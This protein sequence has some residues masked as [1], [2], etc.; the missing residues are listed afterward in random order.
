[1]NKARKVLYWAITIL[2][3]LVFLFFGGMKFFVVEAHQEMFATYGFPDWMRILTGV[4]EITCAVFLLIRPLAKIAALLVSFIMIA[5]AFVH[6]LNGEYIHIA[7]PVLI[8]ILMV[9]LIRWQD[10]RK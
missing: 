2:C 3:S 10:S 6:F 7:V 8:I 1:M 5:A 9:L 4:L